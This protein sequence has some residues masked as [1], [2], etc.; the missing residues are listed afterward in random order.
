MR[1]LTKFPGPFILQLFEKENFRARNC[2][3]NHALVSCLYKID[4]RDSLF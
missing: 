2:T 3:K 4:S 1:S